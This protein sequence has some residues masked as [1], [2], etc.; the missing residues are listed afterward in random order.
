MEYEWDPGKAGLN[1][2]K[3]GIPFSAMSDFNWDTAVVVADQRREYGEARY[4]A[5]GFISLDL[6]SL[7]FTIRSGKVRVISLRIAGRKE[8]T[9]Y[10]RSR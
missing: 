8:R 3:H 2:R 5:I 4:L 6:C 10:E 7:A 9:L 1:L